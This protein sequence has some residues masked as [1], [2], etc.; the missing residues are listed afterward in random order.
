MA[1][2]ATDFVQF[3][4]RIREGLRR[5]IEREA[6]K[7]AHSAN[8]EAVRR[9][10]NTFAEEEEHEAFLKEMEERKDK[11]DERQR[12]W[13]EE[14]AREKALFEASLRDSRILNMMV[15]NKFPG[16]LLLRSLAREL[17]DAPEWAATPESK[18]MFADHIHSII[19]Q[20]DFE[21]DFLR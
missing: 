5:K 20:K 1:R 6:E 3:K 15:E 9:I 14:Q 11:D 18:K 16:A 2:K 21:G 17:A 12:Q 13:I 7:R 4:L 10:E 8:A 19:I